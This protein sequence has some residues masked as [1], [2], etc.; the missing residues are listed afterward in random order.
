MCE[1][2]LKNAWNALENNFY[3][4]RVLY[5]LILHESSVFIYEIVTKEILS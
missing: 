4:I 2:I 3:I 1:C 5:Y